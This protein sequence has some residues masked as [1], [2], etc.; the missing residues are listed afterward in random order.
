MLKQSENKVVIE[1]ILSEVN[2]KTGEFEKK[3]VKKEYVRGDIKIRLHQLIGEE[4]VEMEVP[5]FVFS[6]K[7]TNKG[8]INPS[9]NSIM[10]VME[11]YTSIA[12]CGNEEEADRIRVTGAEIRSNEFCSTDGRLVVYP[13]V[14]GSFFSKVRKDEYKPGATFKTSVVI[15]N[16]KDEETKDGDTTGRLVVSAGIVQ[17]GE[18][19]DV[20]DF[21]VASKNAIS[22]INANWEVGDTVIINGKINYSS[23]VEYIEEEMD[24]GDPVIK[25]VTTSVRDFIIVSGSGKGV[26]KDNAYDK[27]EIKKALLARKMRLDELVAEAGKKNSTST[28]SKASD[29]GF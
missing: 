25:P 20:V 29:F 11:D 15:V 21:V 24:F 14:E 18:K 5:V 2:L 16:I 22:H 4:D 28:A 17:Y 8:T 7:Y 6:T 9:Y 19:I 10:H 23:K 27:D 26:S 12:S 1:G 13:R 3:G